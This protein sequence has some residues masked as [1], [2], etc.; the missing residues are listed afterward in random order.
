MLNYTYRFEKVLGIEF[1]KGAMQNVHQFSS[2]SQLCPTL[3]PPGLRHARLSCPSPTPG[4]CSSSCP[5]SW[6]CHPTISSSVIPFCC[7]QSFPTSGSFPMSRLFTSGG[8][9][10]I[11]SASS[12]VLPMSIQSWFPLGLTGLI[13]LQSKE[14]LRN[15][16]C[17]KL[18]LC[19]WHLK[20]T[21]ERITV[22]ME[23][24]YF[25]KWCLCVEDSS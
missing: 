6:W 4:A 14:L 10:I 2:V 11:A 16:W 5:L 7:P 22:T 25:A 15:W 9:S 21:R 17:T 1:K 24:F 18:I 12:L 23:W 20:G 3:Q 13:S 19:I 8:Q